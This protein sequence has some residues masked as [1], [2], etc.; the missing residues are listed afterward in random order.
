MFYT[1][2]GK[3]LA[4]VAP[5]RTEMWNLSWTGLVADNSGVSLSSKFV[6]E[7][8]GKLE[9]KH[10]HDGRDQIFWV[11]H[12]RTG[13][14][15]SWDLDTLLPA[16]NPLD[17]CESIYFAVLEILP[18]RTISEIQ[19]YGHISEIIFLTMLHL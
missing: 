11:F 14:Q 13:G 10:D 5:Y 12:H 4:I 3:N 6:N 2:A 9:W 19:K 18:N 16:C 8:N 1:Y 7:S 17:P 15:I